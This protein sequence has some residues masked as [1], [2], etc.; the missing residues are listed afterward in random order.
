M[1][2]YKYLEE[3]K[4]EVVKYYLNGAGYGETAIIL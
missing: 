3:F 2:R 1:G 4:L